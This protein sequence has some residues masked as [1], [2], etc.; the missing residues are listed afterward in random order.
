MKITAKSTVFPLILAAG[1]AVALAALLLPAQSPAELWKT[2]RSAVGQNDWKT[3]TAAADQLQKLPEWKAH[4]GL[5]RGYI[6]RGN[7]HHFA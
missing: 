4:A 7:G 5:L 3:A 1:S 2:G 6:A